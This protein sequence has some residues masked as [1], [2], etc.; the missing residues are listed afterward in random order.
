MMPTE[1]ALLMAQE[2]GF[3]LVEVSPDVLPPV[4][5]IMDYGK[6][7][8]RQKKRTHQRKQHV[9]QLKE[10]WARP[11]TDPHDL[12]I[13]VDHAKQFLEHKD[14]VQVSVRFRGRE[15]SHQELGMS[16]LEHFRQE[17]EPVAKIEQE[18]KNTGKRITMVFAPR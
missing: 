7:K 14:K 13:K 17:L 16:V 8:Y 10:I 18:P 4:C 3:D 1:Q 2:S 11:K 12:K 9:T 15:M 5:R 6:Y